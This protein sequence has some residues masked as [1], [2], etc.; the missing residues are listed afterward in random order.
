MEILG[1]IPARGN[2]KGLKNKNL[3]KIQNKTLLEYSISCAKKSKIDR[4]VVSTDSPQIMK[5]AK[6]LGA[7]V[8]FL[9]PKKYAMDNSSTLS[10]VNHALTYLSTKEQYVP[11]I[12]V[13]LQPTS[14]LRKH[15]SIN[16]SIKLL[17]NNNITSILGVRK[18]HDHPFASFTLKNKLLSPYM[19]NSKKYYQRQ[20]LPNFY[21]PTGSIYTFWN[22]TL[23]KFGSYYGNKIFPLII[24]DESTVDID[25][26]LDLF[27]AEMLLKYWK[28]Y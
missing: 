23:K 20:K 10:V 7:D 27:M 25:S 24:D 2:S 13:I 6:K 17:M 1:L 26:K 19:K 9:R 12:I 8:P 14:P 21:F 11:D 22:S 15:N 5:L 18:I 28:K 16:Q 3:Q 4:I